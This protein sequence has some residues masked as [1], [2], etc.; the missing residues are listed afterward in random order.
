MMPG[1]PSCRS[2]WPGDERGHSA[3]LLIV[4]K[5]LVIEHVQS[6]PAL[7]SREEH[8]KGVYEDI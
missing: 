8:P 7:Q 2:S 1:V 6:N 4:E 5:I 3:V